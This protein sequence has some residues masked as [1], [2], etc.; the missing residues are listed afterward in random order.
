ML[1]QALEY[2]GNNYAAAR[3]EDFTGHAVAQFVRQ[4]FKNA[5]IEALG[6]SGTGLLVKGSAGQSDWAEVPWGAILEPLVSTGASKG[7]YVVYLFAADRPAVVLSLNQATTEV[8]Q[9]FGTARRDVVLGDRASFIRARV[10]DFTSAFPLTK[11]DL[12]SSQRLPRGYEAGHAIGKEYDCKSLPSDDELAAD[13]RLLVQAYR[14]L[15]Y[16]G[17]VNPSGEVADDEDGDRPTT[18]LTEIRQYRQHRRIDRHPK[19][20]LEAKKYH[21]TTCQACG[22]SFGDRYGEL[23]KGFIEAHHLK[24]LSSLAEGVAVAY[25]VATDFAVL[26]A[27]CHRMIHRTQDPSDLS[28]FKALIAAHSDV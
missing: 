13:L 16:R 20:S 6:P 2:I 12:G 17:G 10:D 11:I 7:Y 22:F 26:C 5:I 23:G 24:P 28:S 14:T 8:E 25:D 18:S 15:V 9:E 19:A 4:D 21:G 27:N 3:S 1:R